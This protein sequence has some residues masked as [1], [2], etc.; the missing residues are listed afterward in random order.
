MVR[1]CDDAIP[2]RCV[3]DGVIMTHSS[4]VC[5]LCLVRDSVQAVGVV[6][7]RRVVVH[8]GVYPGSRQLSQSRAGF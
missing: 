8:A 3:D 6:G 2:V 4:V 7:R 1:I 5:T